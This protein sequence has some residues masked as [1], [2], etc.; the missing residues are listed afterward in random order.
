MLTSL[1]S[2]FGRMRSKQKAW[3]MLALRKLQDPTPSSMLLCFS[4]QRKIP[5]LCVHK[6]II[7][8]HNNENI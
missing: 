5:H 2:H 3:N 8:I 1:S 6:G 4:L 7:K